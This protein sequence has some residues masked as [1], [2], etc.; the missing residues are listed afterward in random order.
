VDEAKKKRRE[1]EVT[2]TP[3][4]SSQRPCRSLSC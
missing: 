4:F 3:R 2:D 1:K